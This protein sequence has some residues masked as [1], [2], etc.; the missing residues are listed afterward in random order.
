MASFVPY[1]GK[2]RFRLEEREDEFLEV[3]RSG[4]SG[5]RVAEAA[6]T[7]RTAHI[8]ALKEKSQQFAPSERNAAI[9]EEIERA[10]RW[11]T[12]L[13]NDAIVESYRDPKRRRK[14]SSAVRRA[15]K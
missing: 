11:W 15:A 2:K 14:M 12:D 1:Y 5:T 13:P 3:L 9:L 6:E 8:R 10:I 7:V 4:A